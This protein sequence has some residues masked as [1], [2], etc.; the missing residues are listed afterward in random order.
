MPEQQNRFQIAYNEEVAQVLTELRSVLAVSTYQAGKVIFIGSTNGKRLYQIPISFRKPMGIALLDKK[1]AVATLDEIQIFASSESMAELF[2]DDPGTYDK[3]FL[4]R[5][6]YYSG[7]TDIHDLSFGVGGLW[8]VNT[9]F[10]CISTYDINHSFTPRWKPK[11]ITDLKPQDRCH[12]NGMAMI[13]NRPAFATAL[14]Q[15]NTTDGWR[16]GITGSGVLMNVPDG[17]II[18]EN[19]AMP[20]SPRMINN[21]L[22]MLLSASGEVI[23]VDVANKNY[24]VIT[25]VDGFIRGMAHHRGYLFIGLSKV[26][27]TSKTFN[28]LP[29]A[30]MADY[31]GVLVYDLINNKQIGTI[32]YSSTVEEIYDVQII[33]DTAKPGLIGINDERHKLAVTTEKI[34]FWKKT[35]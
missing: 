27:K 6:T 30:E 18:L 15:T 1:M 20:H 8:A 17:D 9:K 25:K 35:K 26:R 33:P 22:Y 7:E 16:E 29:V 4:P 28:K 24:K 14:S 31:A 5:A 2:P 11:F 3:L 10:S 32:K 19:L 12:L 21:E 34:S 13:E 23:K